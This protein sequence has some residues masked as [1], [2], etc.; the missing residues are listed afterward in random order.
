MNLLHE[1][2]TLQTHELF[3]RLMAIINAIPKDMIQTS[4]GLCYAMSDMLGRMLTN[5]DIKYHIQEVELIAIGT[6]PVRMMIVGKKGKKLLA[7]DTDTHVVIIVEHEQPILIDLSIPHIMP[8]GRT[9]LMGVCKSENDVIAQ[10]QVSDA[11][12]TYR[13]REGNAFAD[14]HQKSI[15][16]RISTDAS[17]FRNV[18]R[19]Y[20]LVL[21]MFIIVCVVQ[22]TAIYW[23]VSLS[24]DLKDNTIDTLK[25]QELG[26]QNNQLLKDIRQEQLDY[27]KKH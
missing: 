20:W 21:A 12:Y 9:Y 25:A 24:M 10:F 1:N 27:H 17:I 5:A 22:V 23:R 7:T 2:Q 11:T 14:L 18:K 16:E 4:Q 13:A 15:V 6:N 3:P 8:Q 19:L 26:R